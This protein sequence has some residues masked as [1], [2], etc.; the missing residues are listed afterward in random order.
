MQDIIV[1]AL[2]GKVPE[3]LLSQITPLLANVKDM[4]SAKTVLAPFMDKI[5]ADVLN[6]I[7]NMPSMDKGGI[8]DTVKN[9]LGK[10]TGK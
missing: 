2:K 8:I 5:P 7:P 10:L 1:N 3:E 4:E 9:M 6:N